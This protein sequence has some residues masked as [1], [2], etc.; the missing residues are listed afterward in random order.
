MYQGATETI[1]TGPRPPGE[2]FLPKEA[3]PRKTRRGSRG[4]SRGSKSPKKRRRTKR[5]KNPSPWLTAGLVGLGAAA[6]GGVG[7]WLVYRRREKAKGVIPPGNGNGPT[8]TPVPPGPGPAPGPGPGPGPGGGGGGGG[9]QTIPAPPRP[10]SLQ[11]AK[12]QVLASVPGAVGGFVTAA[13]SLAGDLNQWT[14]AAY[15]AVVGNVPIPQ[16]A[17]QRGPDWDYYIE[18]W[19]Y[20]RD[21]VEQYVEELGLPMA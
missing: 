13:G 4:R 15:E 14:D 20:T 21:R 9:G 17:A 16:N 2:A 7:A 1:P 18:L 6:V 19:L 12:N 11:A 5:K 8:P 3:N 10:M